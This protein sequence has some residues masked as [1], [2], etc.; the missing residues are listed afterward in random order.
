[1]KELNEPSSDQ[2]FVEC[3][4]LSPIYRASLQVFLER[5]PEVMRV[6]RKLHVTDPLIDP[7]TLGLVVPRFDLVVHLAMQQSERNE[8]GATILRKIGEWKQ[9]N[10]PRGANFQ[11]GDQ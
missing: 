5:Q 10:R 4:S 1:M 6:S 8:A 9:N 11:K 3:S 2:V 7:A